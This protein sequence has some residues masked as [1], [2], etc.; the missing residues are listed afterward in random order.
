MVDL[1]VLLCVCSVFLDP[2]VYYRRNALFVKQLSS[3]L[4]VNGMAVCNNRIFVIGISS[5]TVEVYDTASY[6]QLQTLS[7]NVMTDPWD[8]AASPNEPYLY[9]LECVHQLLRLDLSG[10]I[11]TSWML[12]GT[13]CALS[14]SRSS[15]I[16]VTYGDRLEEFDNVGKILRSVR[17]DRTISH[18]SHS[19]SVSADNFLLCHGS[20]RISV[21]HLVCRVDR[22]GRILYRYRESGA[23]VYQPLHLAVAEHGCVL[24]VDVNNRRVQILNEQLSRSHDLVGTRGERA[25]P[26]RVCYDPPRGNV[27]VST[28][29]GNV[30]VYHVRS[31][32]SSVQAGYLEVRSGFI[33]TFTGHLTDVKCDCMDSIEDT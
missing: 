16:V 18:A 4:D 7:V 24:V 10:R 8:I 30:L 6:D 28:L 19:L 29:D 9:V 5:S 23:D 32:S 3:N 11:V 14:I 20:G 33:A 31:R 1:C 22:E 26:L 21:Q 25:W 17:F 27:Y 12:D 13:Q 15:S 2:F